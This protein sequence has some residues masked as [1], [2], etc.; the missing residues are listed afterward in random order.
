[1]RKELRNLEDKWKYF[2]IIDKDSQENVSGLVRIFLVLVSVVIILRTVN[3]LF[4]NDQRKV[5]FIRVH[6][7]LYAYAKWI[8]TNDSK[9]R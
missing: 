8:Y 2:K 1:M 9:L 7:Q 6:N 3:Y 4:G 5:K